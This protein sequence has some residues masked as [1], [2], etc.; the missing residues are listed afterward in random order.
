MHSSLPKIPVLLCLFALLGPLGIAAE[1]APS[2]TLAEALQRAVGNNPALL[3]RQFEERAADAR[4]AQA[5][6]RP[7][8]TLDA[9]IENFLGSGNVQGV[10]ALEATLQANQTIE[11]GG[12]R[13]RRIS[14]ARTEKESTLQ[15]LAVARIDLLARTAEAYAQAVAAQTLRKWLE[16]PLRLSETTLA[17]LEQRV[18]EGSD[19]PVETARARGLVAIA[20]GDLQRAQLNVLRTR[21]ALAACWGGRGEDIGELAATLQVPESLPQIGRFET[22]L[23]EHPRLA[24]QRAGIAQRRAALELEQAQAKQD[25][26]VGGGVRFLREGT[27]AAF[28]AGISVPIPS[29]YRN[30]GNIRAARE[31]LAGAELGLRATETDL[32]AEFIGAWQQLA[33][34]HATA[35]SLQHEILPSSLEAYEAVR[36]AYENGELTFH[37]VVDAQRSLQSVQREA[38]EAAADYAVALARVESLASTS[39]TAT[40]AFFSTR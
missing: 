35:Q 16:E 20:K 15:D 26:T 5:A 34:A 11:R 40:S 4:T 10:R 13:A 19:S 32:H 8:P 2:L 33:S 18:R 21:S 31:S 14:L 22:A 6:E 28:V 37:E 3:A 27:D 29:R 7:A 25:V 23:G 1:S 36:H 38:L 12:K 24:Q 39:F 9:T 17:T 30:Q